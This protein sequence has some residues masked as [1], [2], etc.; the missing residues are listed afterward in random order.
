MIHITLLSVNPARKGVPN[1][2]PAPDRLEPLLPGVENPARADPS[3]PLGVV[4]GG[5]KLNDIGSEQQKRASGGDPE[6]LAA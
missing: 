3:W 2:P 4:L 5:D 1:T 6:A